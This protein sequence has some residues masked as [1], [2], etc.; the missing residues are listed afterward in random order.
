MSKGQIIANSLEKTVMELIL[1][2]LSFEEGIIFFKAGILLME[3]VN[4]NPDI[5]ENFLAKECKKFV[6]QELSIA[7]IIN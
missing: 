2:G 1:Q 3:A 6:K 4:K 7:G 5:D